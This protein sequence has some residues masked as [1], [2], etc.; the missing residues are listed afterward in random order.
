MDYIDLDNL[1]Y[2]A[3][4]TWQTAATYDSDKYI[5]LLTKMTSSIYLF[6]LTNMIFWNQR[7]FYT[8]AW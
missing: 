4:S 2:T 8:F 5:L 1:M 6:C 7:I 3:F